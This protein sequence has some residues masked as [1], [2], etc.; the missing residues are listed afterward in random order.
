MVNLMYEMV[1]NVR[2]N[3]HFTISNLYRIWSVLVVINDDECYIMLLMIS[4][5]KDI[6]DS[7]TSKHMSGNK[8]EF[9]NQKKRNS[10]IHSYW[11]NL[12]TNN[13]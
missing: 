10:I 5:M 1:N 3:R 2:E 12:Y 4:N 9:E 13:K 11:F 8:Y 6:E 7:V